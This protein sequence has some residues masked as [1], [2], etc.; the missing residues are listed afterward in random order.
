MKS[1]L[2]KNTKNLTI[3]NGL[4]FFG[5]MLLVFSIL[6][7]SSCSRDDDPANNDF[8]AGTYKGSISYNDGSTTISKDNGSVFVTKIASGTKYNFR[9]SD[10]IPDLN[11]VE[12][13]KEGDHTLVMI[14]SNA[15]SY[16]RI[17]NSTLKILYSVNGK[18]WTANCTR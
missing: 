7:I 15:T 14:G 18:N 1:K 8:F 12:F 17:D 10:G 16:I 4:K 11:G 9:F 13:N 5:V 2:L 6:A 3:K